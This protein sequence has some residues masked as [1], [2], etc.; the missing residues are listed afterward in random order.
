[1]IQKRYSFLFLILLVSFAFQ[2]MARPII[3]DDQGLHGFVG[4]Q[5][6]RSL[7]P[8]PAKEE[9][10][11]FDPKPVSLEKTELT[12]Q[13]KLV[14]LFQ[15]YAQQA[16]QPAPT[17]LTA[18]V[19]T[20]LNVLYGHPSHPNITLQSLLDETATIFGKAGLATMLAQPISDTALLTARQNLI[21][22]LVENEYF[23][24]QVQELLNRVRPAESSFFGY[25]QK[26]HQQV[27]RLTKAPYFG[28]RLI[29]GKNSLNKSSAALEV[30]TRLNNAWTGFKITCPMIFT[31]IGSSINNY[32]ANYS[33]KDLGFFSKID[34]SG[35]VKNSARNLKNFVNPKPFYE[36]YVK[37]ISDEKYQKFCQPYQQKNMAVPLSKSSFRIVSSLGFG[38]GVFPVIAI[39]GSYLNFFVKGSIN[40]AIDRKNIINYIHEQLIDVATIVNATQQITQLAQFNQA[41]NNGLFSLNNARALFDAIGQ[42]DDFAELVNLLQKNTFKGSASFFSLSGRVLAAHTL[43][44]QTKDNFT[45]SLQALGELDACLALAK[46]YKKF[47]SKNVG[48]CFVEYRDAQKPYLELNEFWN[49][50]LNPET[51]VT[52]SVVLNGADA[53]S[54]ILTGSNMGGKSTAIKAIMLNLL[55]AQT[56]GI[57]A[58]QQM[59]VTP[60]THLGTSLNISDDTVAGDSLF[61]S[62]V[63]RARSIVDTVDNTSADKF[64]FLV[65]DELFT[66]TASDKGGQA[67]CN[68]AQHL[69]EKSN[70]LF[71][72]ATHFPVVTSLE[73]KNSRCR[74]MK[75]EIYKKEDGS[76]DPSY[77]MVPGI[78]TQNIANDILAQ[79]IKGVSF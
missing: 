39:V 48:F 8:I 57:A 59:V 78:S 11:I 54:I 6:L 50:F 13:E 71:V 28:S 1:M 5:Y 3:N 22:E 26:E 61:K 40:K 2:S 7:P 24:N 72:F 60:F 23:F 56:C 36:A 49:P 15:L 76:F 64:V 19:L 21:K 63:N 51:A 9:V 16:E 41:M 29:P 30:G 79:E 4:D 35:A 14:I 17:Q 65:I 38:I 73:E 69:A 46:T 58:A 33:K 74:N 42:S 10:D 43:M 27:A 53:N 68:V 67:A 37:M 32:I 45:A 31:T 12:D 34:V 44:K 66:G 55:L 75:M 62:E 25:W 70:C 77:K 52:N 20:D 18:D 47:A